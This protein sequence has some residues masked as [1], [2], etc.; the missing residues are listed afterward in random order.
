MIYI[1]ICVCIYM[2]VCVYIYIYRGTDPDT[3]IHMRLS[4]ERSEHT[5]S[6][7]RVPEGIA[8]C[9]YSEALTRNLRPCD[10]LSLEMD[11]KDR[12][13]VNPQ[14]PNAPEPTPLAGDP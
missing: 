1:Y 13:P 2:Y 4:M 7:A 6:T 3:H 11:P 12:N 14:T 10:T 8:L 9:G 5:H